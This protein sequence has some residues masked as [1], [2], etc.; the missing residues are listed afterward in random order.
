VARRG[1]AR[2]NSAQLLARH[3]AQFCAILL[4]RDAP[5]LR[6]STARSTRSA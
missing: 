5:S 3:S 6:C 4:T 1:G 2:R